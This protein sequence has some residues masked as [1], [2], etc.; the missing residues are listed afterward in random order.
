MSV[1]GK[2]YAGAYDSL[3]GEKDYA[4]ECDMIEALMLRPGSSRAAKL[5][6][7][8]CGT[9]N[10]AIPLAQRGHRV[11]GV[12][13]SEAMLIQARDKAS[14]AGISANTDFYLGD[15]RDIRLSAGKFDAA[16]MM[17]AVLGY[18]QTDDDVLAALRT[19]RAH[20]TTGAPFI[21]DVWYG[22]GVMADKPGPRE[23]IIEQDGERIVRRT[24][25]ILDE[26]NH[27]CTVRFNLE[28]WRHE[29]MIDQIRE[30]H[31]MRFFFPDELEHF[32]EKSGFS[33]VTLRNFPA[34][35]EVVSPYA[36]NTVGVLRA[37]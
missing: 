3:Y 18:Q 13:L 23:R 19:A 5:L 31:R 35:T 32:A 15:V 28:I 29:K 37:I 24:D 25:S 9:G 34:W 21:F 12:D 27:L 30:E 8:G 14:A 16:I 6:D 17:F 26:R 11:S 33:L 4:S 10:H 22:P 1:F 36:W 7:L 20:I 2:T